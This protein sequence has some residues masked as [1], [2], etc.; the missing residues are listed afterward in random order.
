MFYLRGRLS[1]ASGLKF[2][3]QKRGKHIWCGVPTPS[4][5]RKQT[6]GF[7]K[8]DFIFKWEA[9]VFAIS[10]WSLNNY[11]GLTLCCDV[12][13]CRVFLPVLWFSDTQM[14]SICVVVVCQ[15]WGR[16][17][18]LIGA[19]GLEAQTPWISHATSQLPCPISVIQLSYMMMMMMK[20]SDDIRWG[21]SVME[22]RIS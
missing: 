6:N 9:E 19:G 13:P 1:S 10:F 11:N 15:V 21:A 3:F 17:L 22:C 20:L 8:Q 4:Q 16:S 5:R 7:F 14:D 18:C 12:C 2:E